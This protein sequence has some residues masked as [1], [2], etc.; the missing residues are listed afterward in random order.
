[1]KQR[2]PRLFTE[3]RAGIV[4]LDGDAAAFGRRHAEN[5]AAIPGRLRRVFEQVGQD[6]L[7]QVLVRQ[8]LRGV[9]GQTAVIS[10][11]GMRRLEQRDALL[12]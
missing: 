12:Q 7:E 4:Y 5:L 10:H 1:M 6:P 3:A 8:R 11:L 2:I 9:A